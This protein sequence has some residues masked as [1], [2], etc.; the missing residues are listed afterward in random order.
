M[1]ASTATSESE[2][3]TYTVPSSRRAVTM[4]PCTCHSRSPVAAERPERPSAPPGA[5]PTVKKTS[6][7]DPS[8]TESQPAVSSIGDPGPVGS[9]SVPL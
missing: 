1:V 6:G 5:W 9:R 4:V 7:A 8:S 3:A 2:V